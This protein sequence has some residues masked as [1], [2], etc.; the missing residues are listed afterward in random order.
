MM[1]KKLLLM[2]AS[3]MIATASWAQT[4]YKTFTVN[5]VS[6]KMIKVEGG[7]F[8]MG[9]TSEQGSDALFDEKPVHRVTLSDYYIGE[10]EVTQALW[11]A[12]MGTSIRQQRDKANTSW[13]I[14]GEGANYPMYYISWEECWEFVEKLNALTGQRFYMPS[15]AQWEYAARG[16]KKSRGYKYSGSNTVKSVAWLWEN[17]GDA[18]LSGSVWS[19]TEVNNNNC[20]AHPVKTKQANEL[21]LYDMSGN[22]WEWT[23]DLYGKY[24]SNAETNPTGPMAGSNLRVRRGGHWS[25]FADDC[26]VSR[27]SAD[28]PSLRCYYLGLRLAL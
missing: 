24:G 3:M 28:S 5:G 26:R 23:Q 17:S 16:G 27:R 1:K 25:T 6:F 15:E 20:R 7:T 11:Q 13:S 9:A 12:V 21:G 8:Q 18:P 10:T 22:V 19:S 4:N 14:D 2:A